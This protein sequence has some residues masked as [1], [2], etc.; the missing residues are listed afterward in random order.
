[1][2]GRSSARFGIA[3]AILSFAGNAAAAPLFDL[4]IGTYT[5][6]SA[7][8]DS[9]ELTSEGLYRLRFDAGSGL[10]EPNPRQV[11][12]S[13]NPSWLTLNRAATRLF[14]ANENGPG[15]ADPVGRIS[16]LAVH[17]TSN[18][19]TPLTQANTLGDEPTHVALSAD[20]RY[21]FVSNYGSQANP[22]GSLVVLPVDTRGRIGAAVQLAT[23]P[24]S[25]V[26]PQRQ[27]SPHVHSA[28]LSPD[29]RT[30]FV[31]D[32][33][34]DRL[35]AYRY[36]PA[37]A[38]RPLSPADP[39]AI[40]LPPGSGPR[41]LQ[42]SGDGTQ[43]FATLELSAQ[44]AR[45]DHVDGTLVLRQLVDLAPPGEG[46]AHSPGALHL[47]PDGRF[48]YVSDRAAT[49]QIRVF[50]IAETQSLEEIQRRDSEGREPREFAID[51]SGNY[52]LVA[53]QHSDSLVVMRRDPDSGLLGE[54]LQT[55][56][57]AQPADLKFIDRRGP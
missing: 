51:P 42:F 32:L 31:S 45:F 48:L 15:Q 26:H 2:H 5:R 40:E 33:G 4:L 49:N 8:P 18:W 23:H 21:L 47:S 28:V 11:V 14:V 30:L 53:N 27:Q 16:S 34:A 38:E 10:L 29:G 43:A 7:R 9:G 6:E 22:G 19:L 57:L 55:L 17:P 39:A 52:L 36:D 37:N 1:M 35:F 25:G 13:P 20:E 50:T 3:V 41:H 44:V 54:T 12:A 56:P 46:D 24:A